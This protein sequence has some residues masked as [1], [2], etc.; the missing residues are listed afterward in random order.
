MNPGDVVL[1]LLPGVEKSKVRP[2][3]IIA[4]RCYLDERPDAIL[5]ILTTRIPPQLSSSDYILQDWREAGL[6]APS[7]FR[8][9]ALTLRRE[10]LVVIGRLSSRDWG[11]VRQRVQVALSL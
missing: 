2:A 9:F 6:R 11:A 8:M 4:S 1:G 5:G 3:I 7:C 10:D